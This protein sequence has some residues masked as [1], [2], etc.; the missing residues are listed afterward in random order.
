MMFISF[1][2]LRSEVMETVLITAIGSFSADATIKTC[3]QLGMRVIGIDIYPFEWLPDASNVSSFYK[4]PLATNEEE[5]ILF[6]KDLIKK[7]NIKLILPTTDVEVD[8]FNKNRDVLKKLGVILCLSDEK[9]INICRNK[10]EIFNYLLHKGVE[11][12][13][14]TQLL[15]EADITSLQYPAVCKPSN[16][17]SSQGLQYISTK[18]EMEIF[19]SRND[20][21]GYVVQPK[22]DGDI[23]TVDVVFQLSTKKGVAVPRRELLRTKNGAGLSVYVINDSEL[24]R[25]CLKIAEFLGVNGCVNFEFIKDNHNIFHFIECNPRFSGGIEFSCIAAYQCIKN[26]IYCFTSKE[27]ENRKDFSNQYIARKYEEYVTKIE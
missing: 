2:I 4:A 13:I 25:K 11:N 7:E 8:V 20:I 18:E 15:N 1:T 3:K 10:Y 21:N 19:I 12:L 14:P 6:I 23:Y 26:H 9:S 17:R 24:E 22:I 27:I 16:G 5:Y